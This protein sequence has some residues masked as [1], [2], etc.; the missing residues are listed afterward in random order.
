VVSETAVAAAVISTPVTESHER[1]ARESQKGGSSP[2]ARKG[3]LGIVPLKGGRG[4]RYGK[5]LA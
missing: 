2:T 4:G 5:Y 3:N 1:V